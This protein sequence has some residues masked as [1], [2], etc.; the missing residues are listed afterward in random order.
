MDK[1]NAT[2]ILDRIDYDRKILQDLSTSRSYR[3][4]DKDPM[5]KIINEV[6]KT[7][8]KSTLDE[9]IKKKLIPKDAIIPRDLWLT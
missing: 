1:G 2:I 9:N 6:T 5:K 8:K 3:K 4:L 7:I